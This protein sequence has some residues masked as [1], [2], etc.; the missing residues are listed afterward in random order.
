V[1]AKA[2]NVQLLRSGGNIKRVQHTPDFSPPLRIDPA[3]IAHLPKS[4]ERAI[5]NPLRIEHTLLRDT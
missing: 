2:G 5:G 3:T 4:P 1:E